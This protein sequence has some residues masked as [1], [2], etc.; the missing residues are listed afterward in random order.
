MAGRERAGTTGGGQNVAWSAKAML[1]SRETG[2]RETSRQLLFY[3]FDETRLAFAVVAL[4]LSRPIA[5]YCTCLRT[6]APKA[7]PRIEARLTLPHPRSALESRRL[8]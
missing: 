3:L 1:K 4:T 5:R 6:P 2:E 7:K 8:A